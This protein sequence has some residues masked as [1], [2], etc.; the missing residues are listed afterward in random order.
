[1][2]TSRHSPQNIGTG[3]HHSTDY[4]IRSNTLAK[5]S[6]HGTFPFFDLPREIR[7][8]IY[9][10]AFPTQHP[11]RSR[12][13]YDCCNDMPRCTYYLPDFMLG[14]YQWEDSLDET[15]SH[16]FRIQFQMWPPVNQQF[17]VETI[18]VF[19]RGKVFDIRSYGDV[20][21][22]PKDR[23]FW[24]GGSS[25]AEK[26]VAVYRDLFLV[27]AVQ[28]IKAPRIQNRWSPTALK[29]SNKCDED[30]IL[31]FSKL[32]GADA[33]PPNLELEW[34]YYLDCPKKSDKPPTFSSPTLGAWRNMFAKVAITVTIQDSHM[35]RLTSRG[36]LTAS[37]VEELRSIYSK[38][39]Q[40]AAAWA[41]LLVK[42]SNEVEPRLGV[43]KEMVKPHWTFTRTSSQTMEVVDMNTKP[44]RPLKILHYE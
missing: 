6:C 1:M 43:S 8:R 11:R 19:V 34:T 42:T 12:G 4:N 30:A 38:V 22:C 10:L 7:D 32:R 24:L 31:A 20:G 36:T 26:S 17:L 15:S 23:N 33:L 18:E 39:Q 44:K 28:S 27:R 16:L 40:Q 5:L 9:S 41:R 21:G 29:F 14:A 25:A 2:A 35:S 3:A 13:T 37:S